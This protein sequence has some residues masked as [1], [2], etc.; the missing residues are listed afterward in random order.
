MRVLVWWCDK[1]I[2]YS[3]FSTFALLLGHFWFPSQKKA[4][5]QKVIYAITNIC[6]HE[7]VDSDSVTSFSRCAFSRNLT[8]HIGYLV[9][10]H[11]KFVFAFSRPF[12]ISFSRTFLLFT[13]FVFAHGCAV[14]RQRAGRNGLPYICHLYFQYAY[15]L[16]YY[17]L[18]W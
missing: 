15:S 7:A 3:T 2:V 11:V 13:P 10:S 1:Y 16:G 9:F 6:Y 17:V 18:T 12:A 4:R 5:K 8:R 14:T